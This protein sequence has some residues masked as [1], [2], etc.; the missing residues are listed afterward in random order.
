M[1]FLIA[2]LLPLHAAPFLLFINDELIAD[3]S[4]FMNTEQIP[5]KY[6]CVVQIL[7]NEFGLVIR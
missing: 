5:L 4:V 3:K 2:F 1:R 6:R 7:H